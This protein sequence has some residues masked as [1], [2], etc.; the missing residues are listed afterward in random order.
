MMATARSNTTSSPWCQ[1]SNTTNMITASKTTH[2]NSMLIKTK[3]TTNSSTT[4]RLNL[5][6]L[7]TL[8][9]PTNYPIPATQLKTSS[10]PTIPLSHSL[11]STMYRLH[12]PSWKS[13][14]KP[15]SQH[16]PATPPKA[17]SQPTT[18]LSPSPHLMIW[19]PPRWKLRRAGDQKKNERGL[20]LKKNS[21]S[22]WKHR[23]RSLSSGLFGTSCWHLLAV[24]R[25]LQF[26]TGLW[27]WTSI[28]PE[29]INN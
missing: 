8:T 11:Y 22:A 18:M 20:R 15:S 4:Q 13:P 14:L 9:K 28:V 6:S 16:S 24:W 2:S 7:N 19:W 17:S 3:I 29:D 25:C 26:F 1:S 21:T 5:H 23:S 27:S 12:S 10:L